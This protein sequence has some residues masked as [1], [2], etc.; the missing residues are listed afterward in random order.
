LGSVQT[1]W[2][3]KPG[4]VG[5]GGE[6]VVVV[7]ESGLGAPGV[8][9]VLSEYWEGD[10]D[11]DRGPVR[12]VPEAGA[13]ADADADAGAGAAEVGAEEAGWGLLDG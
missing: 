13:D 4:K 3:A 8:V 6:V 1:A 5:W 11:A 7:T 10:P 2:A 12:A 9:L